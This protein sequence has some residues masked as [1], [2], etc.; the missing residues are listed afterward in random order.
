MTTPCPTCEG[1]GGVHGE[2]C[3]DCL[4]TG[5]IGMA[6]RLA[7]HVATLTPDDTPLGQAVALTQTLL[8]APE[9]QASVARWQEQERERQQEAERLEAYLTA[10]D[11]EVDG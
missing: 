7:E 2:A 1:R 3:T 10:P 9:G 6:R 11:H 4:G 5:E 8:A